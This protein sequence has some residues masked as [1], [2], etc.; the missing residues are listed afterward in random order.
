MDW[1]PIKDM[2]KDRYAVV[3]RWCCGGPG[4]G[5]WCQLLASWGVYGER[6]GAVSGQKFWSY[7]EHDRPSR[8]Y[9]DDGQYAEPTHFCPIPAPPQGPRP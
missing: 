7:E 2:P 6:C 1:Q 8:F 5:Y 3:G 9:D 4:E